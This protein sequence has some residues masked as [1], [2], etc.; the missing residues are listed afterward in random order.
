MPRH[1]SLVLV[2]LTIFL[3]VVSP[4]VDPNPADA[5]TRQVLMEMFSPDTR[6]IGRLFHQSFLDQVPVPQ[7]KQIL[8]TYRGALGDLEQ[9]VGAAGTYELVFTKGK[10]PCRITLN[11]RRQIVGLWFGHWTLFDDSP[12]S[13]REEFGRFPGKV[14]VTLTRNGEELLFT[15]DSDTPLAVGSAFKLYILQAASESVR[16]GKLRWEQTVPLR[17]DRK[18]LPS[19]ILQNWPARS[20]LTVRTMANLMISLSD[21]TATDHLLFLLGREQVE[22]RAPERLRPF[23]STR[24]MFVLKWGVGPDTRQRYAAAGP[25]ERRQLLEKMAG[26]PLKKVA[27]DGSPVMVDE[28][29]WHVTTRELCR[30]MYA[31]RDDPA[32]AI[33]PGLAN[34]AQWSRVGYKGGSEPGVLNFTHLLQPESSGPVYVLSATV[35][36]SDEAI[37]TSGFALLVSRLMSLIQRDEFTPATAKNP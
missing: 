23:L 11:S 1:L 4:A 19:G 27:Y 10:A 14:S 6:D 20:P 31:L 5:A 29:E 26:F 13:L 36:H 9:I 32:L 15:L 3:P 33:N 21:N 12:C 18:S 37:D 35:N 2:F 30:L 24:E 28:I 25:A 16:A 7:V 34:P 22:A 17:D 8:D